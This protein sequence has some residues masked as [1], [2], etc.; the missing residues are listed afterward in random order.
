LPL[1]AIDCNSKLEFRAGIK[2][3]EQC[4]QLLEYFN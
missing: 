3:K 1:D 4:K 2:N